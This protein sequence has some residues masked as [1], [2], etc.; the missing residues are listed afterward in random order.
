[1]DYQ[2]KKLE[3]ENYNKCNNIWDMNKHSELAKRWYN[4]LLSGNRIIFIYEVNGEYIGEGSLVLDENDPDYTIPNK[5]IYL[6]RMV[7]K[8]EFRNQGIG[9]LIIDFLISY[10]KNLGYVEMSLGVDIV[11]IGARWLYEKKGF[12]N[13]IFVGEDNDGKYV[14]LVKTL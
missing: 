9:G 13:I 5:R 3:P 6:S 1:M 8:P 4:E 14:K 12:T 7:V 10:A 11:N 2:I